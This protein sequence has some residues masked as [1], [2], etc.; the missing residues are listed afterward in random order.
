MGSRQGDTMQGARELWA[1]GVE[2]LQGVAGWPALGSATELDEGHA[3]IPRRV[4]GTYQSG[5][6]PRSL[7]GKHK[8]RLIARFWLMHVLAREGH[9]NVDLPRLIQQGTIYM[10]S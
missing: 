10:W 7:R 3:L 2:V 8:Y 9:Q 4:P 6:L 5:T 1:I